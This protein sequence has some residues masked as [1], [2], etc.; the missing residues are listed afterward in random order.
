AVSR[1][2]AEKMEDGR[3]TLGA[4][5]VLRRCCA[6]SLCLSVAALGVML[7]LSDFIAGTLMNDERI[8][9]PVRALALCMPFIALSGC[10]KG[11][12]LAQGKVWKNASALIFEQAVKIGVSVALFSFVLSNSSDTGKL[13]MAVVIGTVLGEGASFAYLAFVYLFT[14]K[15]KGRASSVLPIKKLLH[16]TVPL[17]ASSYIMTVL[18]TGESI[19]I[20][21]CFTQYAGDYQASLAAYGM[22]R[23]MVI[24]LLFF[25]FAFLS[26]LVSLL[27][28]ELSRDN[29]REGKEIVK[30]KVTRVMGPV[31]LFS[32]LV[33]AVFFAFPSELSMLFYKTDEC[34]YAMRILAAV[35]P[36]MY[37]ETVSDGILKAL[38]HQ[39]Y[40][41]LCCICNSILRILIIVL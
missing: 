32:L 36:A 41:L 17:A 31:I 11:F 10:L 37:I 7:L 35:T 16:V 40:T 22:V 6:V 38:G 1:L 26:S 28:P 5:A 15:E 27:I 34:A 8:I 30:A 25:P 19:L 2:A 4:V 12:F 13:C 29:A 20:P 21:Q 24:P 18:H 39:H 3:V 14:K 23:G 33:G 9:Q